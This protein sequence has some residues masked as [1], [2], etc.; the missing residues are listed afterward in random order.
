MEKHRNYLRVKELLAKHCRN[1][2]RRCFHIA[3]IQ[4][5]HAHTTRAH[6][7]HAEFFFQTITLFRSQTG[8]AEHAALR[9]EVAEIGA[10]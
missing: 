8:V 9:E 4:A 10:I 6:Q 3:C 5:S 1:R 7:I 2:V